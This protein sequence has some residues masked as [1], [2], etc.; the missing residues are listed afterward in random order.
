MSKMKIQDVQTETTK[1]EEKATFAR[2]MRIGSAWQVLAV[3]L[4][5]SVIEKH[6]RHASDPDLYPNIE[7]KLL[8]EARKTDFEKWK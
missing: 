5:K 1:G 6:L 8:V 4:P 7:R 3:D 2:I